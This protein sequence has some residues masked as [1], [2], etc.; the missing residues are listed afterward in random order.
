[1]VGRNPENPS[2]LY[3]KTHTLSLSLSLS[4]LSL[5]FFKPMPLDLI[6]GPMFAGKS[7]E[8]LR[9]MRRYEHAGRRCVLVKWKGD[10]RYSD[11]EERAE[12]VT[13]DMHRRVALSADTLSDCSPELSS[14]DVVGIDEGQFF[15]D[16]VEACCSL[17][18]TKVVIVSCL[19]GTFE[20]EP[21]P[22]IARLFSK[23]DTITKLSA[24]CTNCK[25]DAPFTKRYKC[26]APAG[27][28]PST[29]IIAVGGAEMYVPCCRLCLQ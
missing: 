6:T 10:T 4:S 18:R 15:P 13:H 1:M 2:I 21:F 25:S 12:V 20:Q 11:G 29:Q 5:S 27:P 7:T 24:V 22:T 3:Q 14:A 26:T 17:A 16:V 19:D 9:R 23:A 8:L 28:S